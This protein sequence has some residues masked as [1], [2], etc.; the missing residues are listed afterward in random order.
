VR[1]DYGFVTPIDQ[2]V[3]GS[4]GVPD[5]MDVDSCAIARLERPYQAP[6]ANR[7]NGTPSC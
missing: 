5:H 1:Y 2:G 6:S 7:R 3:F 4:I